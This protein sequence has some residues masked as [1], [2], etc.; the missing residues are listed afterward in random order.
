MASHHYTTSGGDCLLRAQVYPVIHT[1]QFRV[2]H[3][4]FMDEDTAGDL[5]SDMW[6]A[7]DSG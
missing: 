6:T 5:F 2:C 4:H 1:L 7:S 3:P